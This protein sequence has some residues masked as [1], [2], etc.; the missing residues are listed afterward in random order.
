[1]LRYWLAFVLVIV[2]C[3]GLAVWAGREVDR[4]AEREAAA[5]LRAWR[6]LAGRLVRTRLEDEG[7]RITRLAAAAVAAPGNGWARFTSLAADPAVR[8]V[9]PIES[10]WPSSMRAPPPTQLADHPLLREA[11][12]NEYVL[13]DH[14][15]AERCYRSVL[16]EQ[17]PALVRDEAWAGLAACRLAAGDRPG[18]GGILADWLRHDPPQTAEAA[19]AI[20]LDLDRA[21]VLVVDQMLVLWRSI[22]ESGRPCPQDLAFALDT[23]INARAVAFTAGQREL[24]SQRMHA[25]AAEQR[26]IAWWTGLEAQDRA[27]AQAATRPRP[28][29]IAPTEVAFAVPDLPRQRHV[30]IALETGFLTQQASSVLA[31]DAALAGLA[32][33]L[34]GRLQADPAMAS[35]LAVAPPWGGTMFVPLPPAPPTGLWPGP[36][37]MTWLMLAGA[38]ASVLAGFAALLVAARRDLRLAR[39]KSDFVSNVSHELKTPIALVRL[40]G[41]MLSLGYVQDEAGRAKAQAVIVTEAER[42]GL[43]VENVLDFSRIERGERS[44]RCEPVDLA[45]LIRRVVEAYRPQLDAGGFT[46]ELALA[47]GLPSLRGDPD[48]LT[49]VLLNLL[50]NACKFSPG[51]KRLA[52]GLERR[53]RALRWTVTDHGIGIPAG[54]QQ[55][56]FE[57]F[58]RV[59]TGLAR[60]TRGAGIGLALVRHIV[61]SHH[62]TVAVD[63]TPGQG[64]TFIITLPMPKEE[65]CPTPPS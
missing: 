38:I 23:A 34:G 20:A 44:Y 62:G 60:A 19:V 16:A 27:D 30:V 43:L 61:T 10:G 40:Y 65:L 53:D 5:G 31:A 50:A 26:A 37:T 57:P 8:A 25:L 7:Q 3:L 12:R 39:L 28:L 63:S 29:T 11:R 9:V 52:V 1:M 48:A 51:D 24:W 56:I 32:R 15:A 18:A 47:D 42:L 46:L 54:E 64:A 58:Y 35:G 49:Q 4:N 59:E 13:A 55:R 36:R 21:G 6:D 2:P 41:E 14:A 33:T 17:G 22:H 45:A